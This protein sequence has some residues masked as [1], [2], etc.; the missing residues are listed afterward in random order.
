MSPL[1]RLL[2]HCPHAE[3]QL[4]S[5]GTANEHISSMTK[6]DQLQSRPSR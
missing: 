4:A 1:M 3:S 2:L 5:S 6:L